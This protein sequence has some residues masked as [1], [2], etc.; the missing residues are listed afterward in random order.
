MGLSSPPRGGGASGGFIHIFISFSFTD[1]E[2]CFPDADVAFL[3]DSSGSI[4]RSDYSKVKTFV[5]NLASKFQ[6][7]PSGSRVAVVLYSTQAST[8]IRFGAYTSAETFKAAVQRLRHERGYTR[9]DLAL[10]SAY[11]D[12]FR[13]RVNT[14]FL[15]PK[16]AFV[17]TD[18][19]QTK[20][21]GYTPLDREASRLKNI[22]VRI[23]S[24]GIGKN[25]KRDELKQI[26]S[27]EKDVIVTKTFDTLLATTEELIRT[28]CEGIEG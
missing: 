13:S 21:E 4:R 22:G 6:I 20:A 17:L 18:G 15:A 9:I 26:A 23:I 10:R 24:I 12:L 8:P 16:I 19:E 7:S 27:S 2:N 3:V 28:A 11:F 5:A 25:V 1:T 14:R